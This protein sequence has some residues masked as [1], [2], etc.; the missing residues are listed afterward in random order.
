MSKL[1]QHAFR[2]MTG[3][4]RTTDKSIEKAILP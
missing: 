3:P 2:D 4:D 1:R